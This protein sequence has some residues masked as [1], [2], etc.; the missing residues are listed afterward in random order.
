MGSSQPFT[1]FGTT[2]STW[3]QVPTGFTN[4]RCDL[5]YLAFAIMTPCLGAEAP[6]A[7]VSGK[8]LKFGPPCVGKGARGGGER[9]RGP[10]GDRPHG[11]RCK[12]IRAGTCR[13]R[14]FPVDAELV[15][16]GEVAGIRASAFDACKL[17][18]S[19]DDGIS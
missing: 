17:A 10:H 3:A 6:M 13:A 8:T 18:G 5:W 16:R 15:L 2:A 11:P 1:H 12:S 7:E 4:T 19:T 14:A 9:W